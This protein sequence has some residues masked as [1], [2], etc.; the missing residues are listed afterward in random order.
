MMPALHQDYSLK[1]YIKFTESIP[2][3][4]L[5]QQMLYEIIVL[6]ID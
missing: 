2:V 5:P 4:T 6:N 3:D 1:S